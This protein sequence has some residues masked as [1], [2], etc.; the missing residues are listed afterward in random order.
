MKYVLQPGQKFRCAR[1]GDQTQYKKVVHRTH[2]EEGVL[3]RDE[4]DLTID[5]CSGTNWTERKV[6]DG[7]K[8]ERDRYMDLRPSATDLGTRTWEVMLTSLSGGGTG[9]GPG[10][11]YPNGHR[12]IA[13][14]DDGTTISFYQSGCFT[15]VVDPAEFELLEGVDGPSEW[16]TTQVQ[17]QKAKS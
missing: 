15:S 7:W 2:W 14:S 16:Q 13:R 1:F 17:V 4:R 5:M 11:V 6:E 8:M 9:H 10:D 3:V 12:V